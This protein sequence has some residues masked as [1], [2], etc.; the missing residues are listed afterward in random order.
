MTAQDQWMRHPE[1]GGVAQTSQEAFDALWKGKGWQ[2][3]PGVDKAQV[4]HERRLREILGGMDLTVE[5]LQ[6]Q[7]KLTLVE[8]AGQLGRTVD[9]NANKGALLETVLDPTSPED[10]TTTTAQ[11]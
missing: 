9:P 3:D 7:T 10:G 2:L 8:V 1:T 5:Q 11:P 4:E 6:R